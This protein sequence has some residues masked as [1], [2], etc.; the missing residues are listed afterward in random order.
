M[1]R[2]LLFLSTIVL[3][4]VS[5]IIVG[6]CVETYEGFAESLD[7]EKYRREIQ[8]PTHYVCWTGGYDSTF[9]VCQLIRAHRRV[10]PV[11]LS[12]DDVDDHKYS[13]FRVQRR[14]KENEL[15]SMRKIRRLLGEMYPQTAGLLL[16]T[17]CINQLSGTNEEIQKCASYLHS[18]LGWFTRKVNQYE[19]ILQ[20][21]FQFSEPLEICIEKADDGLSS[22][23][24][25]RVVGVGRHCRLSKRLPNKYKCACIFGMAR[26]PIIHLTKVEM[27]E[28]ARREGYETVLAQSWSCWTPIIV[29]GKSLP[30]G[31]CDMCRHRIKL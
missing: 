10:Q 19:R 15:R 13:P 8:S 9:R 22:S 23:I 31:Q 24:K 28:I 27:L 20:V 1:A 29:N 5:L 2:R 25:K 14:N 11:Y 18:K 7:P 16:P 12:M 17:L 6:L 3:V 21:A 4:I 26:F 30:C